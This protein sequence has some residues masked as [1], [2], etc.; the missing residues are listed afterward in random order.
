MGGFYGNGRKHDVSDYPVTADSDKRQFGVENIG[1]PQGIYQVCF[2]VM[3]K[4]LEIDLKN[5]GNIF[6]S[7]RPDK[8]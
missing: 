8:K 2:I 6:G 3:R 7:F 1:I 5:C 4:R